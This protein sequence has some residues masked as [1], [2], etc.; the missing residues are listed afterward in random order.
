MRFGEGLD[1]YDTANLKVFFCIFVTLTS[2]LLNL[3]AEKVQVNQEM[4]LVSLLD[5]NSES[6]V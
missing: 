6:L 2:F 1:F 3:V 4:Y 5:A